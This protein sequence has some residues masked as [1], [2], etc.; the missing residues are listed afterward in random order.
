M[1]VRLLVPWAI[2]RER[3]S[4]PVGSFAQD[5]LEPAADLVKTNIEPPSDAQ[6]RAEPRV[7]GTPLQLADAVEL[8]ADTLREALL[9]QVSLSAQFLDGPPESGMVGRSRFR[10]SAGRHA[11]RQPFRQA[12]TLLDV[13]AANA[14]W[15]RHTPSRDRPRLYE[16]RYGAA[17]DLLA[18]V[19]ANRE[20]GR[21]RTGEPRT[22]RGTSVSPARNLSI[23]GIHAY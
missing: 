2:P 19:A 3:P 7:D 14:I 17:G 20:S 12:H 23:G 11:P 15:R 21:R 16:Y 5:S 1:N 8:G 18:G 13:M 9:G 22:T 6:Q 10:S 4:G